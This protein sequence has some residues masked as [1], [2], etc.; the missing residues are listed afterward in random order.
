MNKKLVCPKC[1]SD[2]FTLSQ[3][4]MAPQQPIDYKVDGYTKVNVIPGKSYLI[5][6]ECWAVTMIN[7]P[8]EITLKIIPKK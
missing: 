5:C 3:A 1:Q 2:N 4:T 6:D 8:S 7:T